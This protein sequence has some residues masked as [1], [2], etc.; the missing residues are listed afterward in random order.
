MP[1]ADIPVV[2]IFC[3]YDADGVWGYPYYEEY[4]SWKT[5]KEA[6]L[7]ALESMGRNED[8]RFYDKD[9]V[10]LRELEQWNAH[11]DRWYLEWTNFL[12]GWGEPLDL[13]DFDPDQFTKT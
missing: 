4:Y 2:R 5:E 10:L 11:F 9:W 13:A 1:N 12:Q 8:L 6:D 7:E 3:D